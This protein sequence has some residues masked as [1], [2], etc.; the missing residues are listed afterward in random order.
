[1]TLRFA[2]RTH[3]GLVRDEN[4]DNYLIDTE[5]NLFVVADGLGGHQ[6]GR[7]ASALAVNMF[8]TLLQGKQDVLRACLDRHASEEERSALLS[9]LEGAL[10][11]T[12]HLV[13]KRAHDDPQHVGMGTTFT[14]LVL[15]PGRGYLAHVGDSRLYLVRDER[16]YQ[17]SED[18]SLLSAL[19]AQGKVMAMHELRARFQ[20]AVTRAVGVDPVLEVNTHDFEVLPGDRFLLCSDGLHE[21]FPVGLLSQFLLNLEDADPE[22]VAERLQLHALEQG[23]RDNITAVWVDT[24]D[25]ETAKA[26]RASRREERLHNLSE[27]SLF[28]DLDDDALA[29]I[30]GRMQE[31]PLARGEYLFRRGRVDPHVY[32]VLLGRL[33]Y[34]RDLIGVDTIQP[35][36]VIG[37]EGVLTRATAAV[38]ARAL[39]DCR[40]LALHRDEIEALLDAGD[41]AAKILGRNLARTL[42]QQLHVHRGALYAIRARLA[43]SEPSSPGMAAVADTLDPGLALDEQV[44]DRLVSD[45]MPEA[46]DTS[47]IEEL[48]STD[49]GT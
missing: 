49:D 17:V 29:S 42:S 36:S 5:L 38:D 16:V 44:I 10:K 27:I 6:A 19:R 26:M 23:G 22:T 41:G 46:E 47:H 3:C 1:M 9:L 7:V 37:S 24:R 32:V 18:H 31:I 40:L 39:T 30:L 12:N 45:A 33:S 34:K 28:R 2:A 11:A 21:Y 13:L 43:E 8:H 35:G 20:N 14:A 48:Q 25:Q 4:Q 15:G